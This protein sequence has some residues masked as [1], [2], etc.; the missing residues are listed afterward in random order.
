MLKNI[1]KYCLIHPIQIVFLTFLLVA[2]G[3]YAFKDLPIDAVP[4]I[5][6]VQV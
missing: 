2:A 1:V 3:I 4:D 6:N 5:T